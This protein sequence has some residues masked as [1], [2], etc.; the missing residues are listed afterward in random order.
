MHRFSAEIGTWCYCVHDLDYYCYPL[1]PV[2][3]KTGQDFDRCLPD[4]SPTDGSPWQATFFSLE[5]GTK[6]IL[7]NLFYFFWVM[8]IDG[9]QISATDNSFF[10]SFTI[11]R[12]KMF[13]AGLTNKYRQLITYLIFFYSSTATK[14]ISCLN[15][16]FQSSE[17]EK[18]S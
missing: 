7:Q 13:F 6:T 15:F 16:H 17:W 10:F 11:Y 12:K 14:I 18:M 4:S 2:L 1:P 8:T 9:T 3:V 5:T